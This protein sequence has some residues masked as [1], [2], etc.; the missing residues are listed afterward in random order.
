MLLLL[1]LLLWLLAGLCFMGVDGS[2]A[3]T[4]APLPDTDPPPP[5]PP[6]VGSL[7][8]PESLHLLL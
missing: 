7:L 6:P 8:L 4:A 5:P 3:R 2:A 1:L